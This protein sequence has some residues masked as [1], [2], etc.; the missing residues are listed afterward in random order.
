MAP[1][2]SD[3]E[4]ERLLIEAQA[5]YGRMT[6]EQKKEMREAQHKSWVVGETMLEHPEMA[7]EQ[8]EEIYEKVVLGL[9]L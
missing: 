9:G 3:P 8:A 4:L 5:C 6:P 7:R 1:R 2:F